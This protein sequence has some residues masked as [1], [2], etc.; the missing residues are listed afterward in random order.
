[1]SESALEPDPVLELLVDEDGFKPT[2]IPA[3][4]PAITTARTTAPI[5]LYRRG[6]AR[7]PLTSEISLAPRERVASKQ[8]QLSGQL[9]LPQQH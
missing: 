2:T 4:M 5:I 6:I 7:Y 1:M 3:A 9:E 8:V